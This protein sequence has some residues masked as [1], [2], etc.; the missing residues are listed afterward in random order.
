[1][2]QPNWSDSVE[3]LNLTSLPNVNKRGVKKVDLMVHLFLN[4]VNAQF[5][6]FFHFIKVHNVFFFFFLKITFLYSSLEFVTKKSCGKSFNSCMHITFQTKNSRM[7]KG[8]S[9]MRLFSSILF[10]IFPPSGHS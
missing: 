2:A 1:M 10:N 8:S 3:F 5:F 7:M 9:E 6:F 4:K